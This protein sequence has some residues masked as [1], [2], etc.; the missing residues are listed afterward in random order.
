MPTYKLNLHPSST[1]GKPLQQGINVTPS[2]NNPPSSDSSDEE[3]EVDF[4][5]YNSEINS[6]REVLSMEEGGRQINR[7]S[8][9]VFSRLHR[10]AGSFRVKLSK[11]DQKKLEERE[12]E[13]RCDYN[14]LLLYV[15]NTAWNLLFS[16][17]PC[18]DNPDDLTGVF[19][20]MS[21]ESQPDIL[22][23]DSNFRRRANKA[24]TTAIE[25]T[26]SVSDEEEE[27]QLCGCCKRKEKEGEKKPGE[28]KKKPPA[29]Q[30]SPQL[31]K[32]SSQGINMMKKVFFPALPHLLQ[33]L[34]VYLEFGITIFAFVFGVISLDLKDGS[35]VFNVVYLVLTIISIILATIDCFLYFVQMGSCAEC[36]KIC[37]SKLKKRREDSE[38]ELLEGDYDDNKGCCRMSK[39]RKEKFNAYFELVRNLV[40]EALLYPLLICDLFDFIVGGVFRNVN[41][42]DHLNFTLFVVGSLYLILS[43]YIMRMFLIVGVVLSLS[44]LP[45]MPNSSGSQGSNIRLLK[46]FSIHI[47]FQ[48]I[49]H[50]LLIVSV[51]LKIRHENPNFGEQETIFASS[52][53][54]I[55]VVLGGFLP[56]VGILT[57][58]VSN[59]YYMREFTI[60][61]WIEM[62]AMLQAPSFTDVVFPPEDGQSTGELALEFVKDSELKKV[63]KQFERYKSPSWF[64]KFLFPIRLPFLI[65][66]GSLFVLGVFGFLVSLVL[67]QNPISPSGRTVEVVLFDDIPLTV[68]FFVCT[69]LLMAFNVKLVVLV[70]VF[71]A[72]S[73][74]VLL[75]MGVMFAV[76][77][78]FIM[79][80]YIPVGC[81]VACY[82]CC[83]GT[84]K[85]VSILSAPGPSV[86]YFSPA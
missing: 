34:W 10:Y 66:T 75:A 73:S 25:D 57:F 26:Q 59:Y 85:E 79:V 53:L 19:E 58:F 29:T 7:R 1:L 61:F 47:M 80:V 20:M 35:K 38:L 32:A 31:Q 40:S 9:S 81:C 51:A 62:M 54:W 5:R 43:V 49:M 56:L 21:H 70:L 45:S 3:S 74:L 41:S 44:R 60:S 22:K 2:N 11:S 13:E 77:L 83:R 15:H 36:L 48:I 65:T 37:H 78:P 33:D 71:F 18:S 42:D 17:C 46:Q 72:I 63:Q 8:E 82:Q 28:R 14:N 30:L 50:A 6:S 23:K 68:A 16:P 12:S 84:L 39:E 69:V 86:N 4:D 64:T 67:T 52:F 24:I 55:M 76:L 27:S